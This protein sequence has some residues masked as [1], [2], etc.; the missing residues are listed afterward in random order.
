[1]GSPTRSARWGE[2]EQRSDTGA[3]RIGRLT[4]SEVCNDDATWESPSSCNR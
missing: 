1:M 2:E 3:V 4:M